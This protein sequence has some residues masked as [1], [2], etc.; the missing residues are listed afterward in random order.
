MTKHLQ[1][2][3]RID[4]RPK[5]RDPLLISG[6]PGIGFVG[7]IAVVHIMR[8]MNAEKFGEVYSPHF[9]DVA[10]S[11]A[12]HGLRRPT[13]ELHFC[14]SPDDKRDLVILYGNTQP[15]SSYGQYEISQK[16]LSQVSE[17]GCRFIISLAGLKQEYVKE[18]PQVFCVGSG[19]DAMDAVCA[20]G[21]IPL[22]GEVY[23]MAGMLVGLAKLE[24]MQA[25]CLLAETLGIYPDAS[26]AKA[27]LEKIDLAYGLQF[28]L[29]GLADTAKEVSE[30]Q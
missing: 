20:K 2:I 21:V 24:G 22:Q 29:S 7:N 23:G 15:L 3:I 8:Q 11:S 12:D 5:L 17:L 9:Q 14:R 25:I 10:Y 18:Q 13:I 26:A 28:N 4:S 1:S 6:L 19:F 16:I 27:V 30:N